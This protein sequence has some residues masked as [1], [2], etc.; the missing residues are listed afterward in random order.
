MCGTFAKIRVSMM[1]KAVKVEGTKQS[2][3]FSKDIYEML[4]KT[5]FIDSI[6]EIYKHYIKTSYLYLTFY[7]FNID[8]KPI[9]LVTHEMYNTEYHN[10]VY[11][12]NDK[13]GGLYWVD[14]KNEYGVNAFNFNKSSLM[15]LN[16]LKDAMILS[17]KEN[18]LIK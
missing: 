8:Y 5:C 7:Y 6:I 12:E 9:S 18:E 14:H 1:R 4:L 16:A 3:F 13:K 2:E 17:G 15:C 11:N 10:M